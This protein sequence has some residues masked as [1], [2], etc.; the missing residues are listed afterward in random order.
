MFAALTLPLQAADTPFEPLATPP[1]EWSAILPVLVLIGGRVAG[2][3]SEL[4]GSIALPDHAW[5]ILALLPLAGAVLA[6]L[7]ARITIQRALGRLL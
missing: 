3:G 6:L 7:V 5:V 4:L 2:I 1:I